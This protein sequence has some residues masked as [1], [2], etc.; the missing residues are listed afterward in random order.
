[1][2]EATYLASVLVTGAL[3]IAVWTLVVRFE[4]WRSYEPASDERHGDGSNANESVTAWVV[5]FL[6]LVAVVG[7]GAVLVVSDASLLAA[8][9]SWAG[10]AGLF[11]LVLGGY[12]LWGVYSSARYRGLHSAQAALLGLWLFGLLFVS[13][14]VAKLLVAG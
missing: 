13:A 9:G 4:A 2:V 7:G 8:V 6:L 5:G 1:M 11:G 3:L 14:V 12:L 10:V